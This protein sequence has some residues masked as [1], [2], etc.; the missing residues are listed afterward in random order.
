MKSNKK[1]E[2]SAIECSSL[3]ATGSI[4]CTSLT[5]GGSI[6][7][8]YHM[9]YVCLQAQVSGSTKPVIILIF[10]AKASSR[11]TSVSALRTAILDTYGEISIPAPIESVFVYSTSTYYNAVLNVTNSATM[12]LEFTG[13][14]SAGGVTGFGVN[15]N[16]LSMLVSSIDGHS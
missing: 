9:H 13:V 4:S 7:I 15:S 12:S 1:S 2:L 3:S 16:N 8:P 11:I 5:I 14:T 6:V 10:A